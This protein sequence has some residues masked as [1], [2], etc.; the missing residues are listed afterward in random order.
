MLSRRQLTFACM[1]F[2]IAPSPE[3]LA[4]HTKKRKKITINPHIRPQNVPF[5]GC[6]R[7]NN[8]HVVDLYSRVP[9]DTKVVVL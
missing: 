3:A 4:H 7:L 8:S 5:S 1:A 6:V 9:I 2:G